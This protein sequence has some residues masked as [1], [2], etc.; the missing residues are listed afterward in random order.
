MPTA[1]IIALVAILL[2]MDVF[3]IGAL[4]A[5]LRASAWGPL[6]HAYPPKP[7]SPDAVR[8]SFQSISIGLFNLGWSVHLAADAEHLHFQPAA[9]LRWFRLGPFSVPWNDIRPVTAPRRGALSIRIK[10]TTIHGPAWAFSLADPSPLN[11]A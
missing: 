11:G 10:N 3:V 4:L 7:L 1:A 2:A 6:E 9:F 5:N 8:K